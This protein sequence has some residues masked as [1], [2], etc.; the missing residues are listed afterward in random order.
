[1]R[2][3]SISDV[4]LFI[5]EGIIVI[6]ISILGLLLYLRILSLCTCSHSFS[7]HNRA[8]RHTRS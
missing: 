1:M 2:H 8:T 6:M 4:H 5:N 7:P 3:E